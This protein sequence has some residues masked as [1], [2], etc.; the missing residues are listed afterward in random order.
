MHALPLCLIITDLRRKRRFYP[1]SPMVLRIT[2]SRSFYLHNKITYPKFLLPDCTQGRG[3]FGDTVTE[4]FSSKDLEVS[5]KIPIFADSNNLHASMVG[6]ININ[7]VYMDILNKLSNEDKLDLISRLVKSMKRNVSTKVVRKDVF[8]G[9]STDG[10]DDI[11][12]ED[13]AEMLRS[14]NIGDSRTVENW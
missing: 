9:F 4:T 5:R 6:S 2:A 13:Y 1:Y 3:H 11:P 8:A 12:T 14:E 10:G 7:D